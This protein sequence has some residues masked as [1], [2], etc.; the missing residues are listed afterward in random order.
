MDTKN[1]GKSD[2]NTHSSTD[3][4]KKKVSPPSSK[5]SPNIGHQKSSYFKPHIVQ[6]GENLWSIAAAY[7]TNV[8]EIM[9]FNHIYH[10]SYIYPGEKLIIPV[11]N[12]T[13]RT[14]EVNGYIEITSEGNEI[15]TVQDIAPHLT[16]LSI[17]GY[18]PKP[19]G[20]LSSLNDARLIRTARQNGVAPL[21]VITN[22]VDGIFNADLAHLVLSY[23]DIRMKLIRQILT[24][25]KAKHYSGIHL[26]FEGVRDED[27][28][29][30]V[31]F[32]ATLKKYAADRHFILSTVL[33]P[34]HADIQGASPGA[35]YGHSGK[36]YSAYGNIADFVVLM[37]DYW[38]WAG[39]PPSPVAPLDQV[40][41]V[42]KNVLSTIAADKVIMGIPLYGYNW[43]FPYTVKSQRARSLSAQAALELAAGIKTP[44]HYDAVAQCPYYHYI[45][46]SG[47]PHIVWFEDERS[48]T[49]KYK[50]ANILGLRGLSYWS[51]NPSFSQ[52][53][54]LLDDMFKIKK[55]L[56]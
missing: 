8:Y 32:L 50:L 12:R 6:P 17:F 26:D 18:Y 1:L 51:L 43:T 39:G 46:R 35:I 49:A 28:P 15:K 31:D 19:D 21:M 4:G 3:A 52:N 37:N 7:Q 10:P 16:Y 20:S 29:L 23:K 53:H 36:D 13:P 24:V 9:G 11:Q 44:I 55:V 41:R 22:F 54:K 33:M 38:G 34:R 30:L 56:R 14:I 45:D 40:K 25:L 27:R 48:I 42:L 47:R 2:Q 5:P